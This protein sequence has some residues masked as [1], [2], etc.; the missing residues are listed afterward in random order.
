MSGLKRDWL[1]ALITKMILIAK[2]VIYLTS[3]FLLTSVAC[4]INADRK[5]LHTFVSRMCSCEIMEI[6]REVKVMFAEI[7]GVERES[8]EPQMS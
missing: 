7:C 4:L 8:K 3:A 2:A 1:L 6:Y 5:F